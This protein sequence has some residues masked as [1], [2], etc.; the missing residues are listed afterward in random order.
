[1]PNTN[2]R[3]NTITGENLNPQQKEA[4]EHREGPLLIIAGAGSGKTKTLTARVR[5][6][7]ASGINPAHII[8][9]TFTNK[10]AEEMRGR[11]FAPADK[12]GS[13]RM[14]TNSWLVMGDM[15]FIGTFH[16]LGVRILKREA[17]K[18][19]RTAAFTIYDADDS[20]SVMK[21][22]LKDREISAE[23]MSPPLLRALISR[24]KNELVTPEEVFRSRFLSLYDEYEQA[25][26]EHNAFDFD[27]LIEK[28][29]W[30]FREHPAILKKYEAL[31]RYILVDE[32]QDVNTAQY[33]F[34]KLLAHNHRNLGV[35]G[36]DAQA[37]YGFRYADFR[38]FLNFEKDWPEAKV[39]TLGQNYRSTAS[40]IEAASNVIQN[41]KLGRQKRLWTEGERGE[42]VKIIAAGGSDEEA[43]EIVERIKALR[44]RGAAAHAPIAI[45]YRTNAQSRALEQEL[46]THNIPYR[47]FG[48]LKFYERKEVKD[49]IAALRCIMNPRDRV[50]RERLE[51][52]L[53]KGAAAHAFAALEKCSV[54][55]PVALLIGKFLDAADY[56]AYLEKKFPNAQDR[57]ENIQEL[58][59][60]A[61]TF[62]SLEEFLERVSL[63]QS[64]DVAA[65]KSDDAAERPVYLMTIHLAK[66]LEFDHVFVAGVSE[67]LL[68]HQMSYKEENGIEEERRLMYVA[69]TRARTTLTLSYSGI[70]SR[71]LLEIP[72]NLT[73]LEDR[74]RWGGKRSA[75][76][77]EEEYIEH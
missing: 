16:S 60:F 33:L 64:T 45:L 66:G 73:E 19:G 11:I 71:Y 36:D 76:G 57:N 35:V 5:N 21:R 65:K 30:L 61:G 56:R 27:D 3:K 28:V 23:R 67:G 77:D 54:A 38:N 47:I 46:I 7:I 49:I 26:E 58:I 1:M 48:G 10:A 72:G 9:I 24:V 32:F 34:V 59:S 50:S 2:T 13:V 52:T 22:L 44:G 15:P 14:N 62:P 63:L 43:E 25:L 74:R 70:A 68:P 12:H 17:A 69:M 29:V 39:V 42:P 6:L 40:I 4:A 37:I 51:K 31:F 20:L 55:E 41:N 53:T 8:A 18:L 75:L